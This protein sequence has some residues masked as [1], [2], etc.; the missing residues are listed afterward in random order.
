MRW[1]RRDF[2]RAAGLAELALPVMR[3]SRQEA[4]LRD[5]MK[6]LP[7]DLLRPAGAH[8]GFVGALAATGEF[9]TSR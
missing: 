4:T 6:V 8:V 3:K 1:S 9:G 5:W 2:D 7:D